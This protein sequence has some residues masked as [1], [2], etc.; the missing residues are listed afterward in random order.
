MARIESTMRPRR[1]PS[2]A[3]IATPLAIPTQ[4]GTP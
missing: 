2:R 3:A 1:K 4:I